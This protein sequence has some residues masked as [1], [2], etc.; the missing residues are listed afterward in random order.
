M[1]EDNV[2]ASGMSDSSQL[3]I[4]NNAATAIIAAV[5]TGGRHTRPTRPTVERP[6]GN[7]GI[8][9]SPSS[10]VSLKQTVELHDDNFNETTSG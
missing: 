5:V 4:N 10:I 8:P 2:S 7:R 3:R 1:L 9:A 6:I